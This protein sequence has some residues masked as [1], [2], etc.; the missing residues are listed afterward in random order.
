MKKSR[1]EKKALAL[2]LQ[3]LREMTRRELG[4][5]AGGQPTCRGSGTGGIDGCNT[6]T[7][8]GANSCCNSN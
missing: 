6:G 5:V 7:G 4:G 1:D 8:C 3:K 2:K